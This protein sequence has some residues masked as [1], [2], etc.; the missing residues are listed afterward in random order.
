MIVF[1]RLVPTAM[2]A[3]DH[4]HFL[5]DLDA[6][7]RD[8]LDDLLRID[9]WGPQPWGFTATHRADHPTAAR[10]G[11]VDVCDGFNQTVLV[12]LAT[13]GYLVVQHPH[14]TN[15]IYVLGCWHD[16]W[17]RDPD[18]GRSVPYL[19]YNCPN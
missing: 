7:E 3:G 19:P 17:P 4:L 15:P 2:P 6:R 5:A 18:T 14:P 16:V 10:V 9:G 8:M 13:R 11:C 1:D 12:R